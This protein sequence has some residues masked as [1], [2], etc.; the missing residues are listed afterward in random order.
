VYRFRRGLLVDETDFAA[1]SKNAELCF[2][3]VDLIKSVRGNRHPGVI[4]YR[5]CYFEPAGHCRA[6]HVQPPAVRRRVIT[7]PEIEKT[8]SA[9]RLHLR[10]HATR[11]AAAF[12]SFN[13][14]P[15]FD[16]L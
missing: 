9:E 16:C 4:T 7:R 2:E 11:L 14:A 6:V 13:C 5:Q 8:S 3:P 1:L 12:I 15:S 10:N